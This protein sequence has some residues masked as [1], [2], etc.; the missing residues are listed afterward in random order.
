MRDA[1][2]IGINM[3]TCTLSSIQQ[4]SIERLLH[5]GLHG[6]ACCALGHVMLCRVGGFQGGGRII[7]HLP[8]PIPALSTLSPGSRIV[9]NLEMAL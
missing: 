1:L 8:S 7:P 2:C 9:G 4:A 3:L 5:A 6:Q